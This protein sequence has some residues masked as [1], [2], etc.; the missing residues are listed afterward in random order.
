MQCDTECG[1]TPTQW[2]DDIVVVAGRSVNR[3]G[4]RPLLVASD[5][6]GLCSAMD[7]YD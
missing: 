3:G 5:G 6:E 1:K 2:N 7:V 4:S